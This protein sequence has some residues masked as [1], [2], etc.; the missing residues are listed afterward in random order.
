MIIN[1]RTGEVS[2]NNNIY[3]LTKTE[4]KALKSLNKN[5]MTTYE[6]LYFA[7]YGVKE[8]RINKNERCGL[9]TIICR[10]KKKTG[11]DIQSYYEY[12]YKI[13]GTNGKI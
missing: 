1:E 2:I 4:I 3:H 9:S 7:V 12:G 11:L 13:G 6:D 10:I 8:N 5:Y